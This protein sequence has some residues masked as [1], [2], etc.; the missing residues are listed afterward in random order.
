MRPKH[1]VHK[2]KPQWD[3][4]LCK[5][6]LKGAGCTQALSKAVSAWEH[7]EADSF[8]RE[9]GPPEPSQRAHNPPSKHGTGEA[10]VGCP[11]GA[12]GSCLGLTTHQS[13]QD[14]ASCSELTFPQPFSLDLGLLHIHSRR[15]LGVG[16]E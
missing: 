15:E 5:R 10:G 8:V 3:K 4:L 9:I 2:H 1:F 14:S 12:W 11:A 6:L 7:H 16:G 13:L